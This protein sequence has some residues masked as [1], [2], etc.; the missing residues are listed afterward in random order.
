[1][2]CLPCRINQLT[3]TWRF[4]C[5]PAATRLH[6]L[7]ARAAA[8][9]AVS[10]ESILLLSV[11]GFIPYCFFFFPWLL[12]FL[13]AKFY[14]S[15][16]ILSSQK[17]PGLKWSVTEVII[18]ILEKHSAC[19]KHGKSF[20]PVLFR[21]GTLQRHSYCTAPKGRVFQERDSLRPKS[22]E[23]AANYMLHVSNSYSFTSWM[24]EAATY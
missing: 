13:E 5:K 24:N 16:D 10:T 2:C 9:T 17:T 15:Q 11:K 23:T 20:T 21:Y 12:C 22:S 19:S 7:A 4:R 3:V 1:M 6:L 18:F 8:Q 14:S